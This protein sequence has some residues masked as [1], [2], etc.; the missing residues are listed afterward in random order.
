MVYFE[1][2]LRR[3]VAESGDNYTNFST[4]YQWFQTLIVP[5]LMQQETSLNTECLSFFMIN[6]NYACK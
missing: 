1:L 2:I 3:G 6:K 4:I 5:A